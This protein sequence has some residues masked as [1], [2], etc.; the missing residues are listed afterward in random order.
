MDRPKKKLNQEKPIALTLY[1]RP[2]QAEIALDR[3][4][5]LAAVSCFGDVREYYWMQ[6]EEYAV[7]GFLE[8][9]PGAY[10]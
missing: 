6:R 1:R 10:V 5:D 9:G 8:F 7:G 2:P 4:Q 3:F